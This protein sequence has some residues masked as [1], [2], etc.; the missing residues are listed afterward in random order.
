MDQNGKFEKDDLVVD[1]DI[2]IDDDIGR[3]IIVYFE[4]WFDVDKKFNIDTASDDDTWLNMYGRYN[5]YEDT[6]SVECV[7]DRED[8]S[9]C[10]DYIPTDSEAQL[11]KD[12]ITTA[13]QNEHHQSPKEF[14]EHFFDEDIQ[15][16][17]IQ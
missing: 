17:G 4:C 12:L 5:P 7:I 9:S 10:F 15:L 16:G 1:R 8:S 6:L 11:M 2:Q 3:E 14:C 13:I